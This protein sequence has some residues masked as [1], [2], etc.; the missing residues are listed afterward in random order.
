MNKENLQIYQ[1]VIFMS[2]LQFVRLTIPLLMIPF[3][4]KAVGVEKYGIIIFAQ[5]LVLYFM[6]IL[7]FGFEM[8]ATKSVSINRSNNNKLSE[9]FTSILLIKIIIFFI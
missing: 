6:I 1:N 8:S 2:I 4:V 7:N 9:I 5:T 3:L